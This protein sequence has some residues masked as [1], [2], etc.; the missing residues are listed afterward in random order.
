MDYSQYRERF[1]ALIVQIYDIL[2]KEEV[3][4]NGTKFVMP[5]QLNDIVNRLT[6]TETIINK[7]HQLFLKNEDYKIKDLILNYFVKY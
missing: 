7:K 2:E 3:L 1:R 6:V 4:K 5:N